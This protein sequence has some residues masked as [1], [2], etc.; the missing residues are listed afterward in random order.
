MKE[1]LENAFL[2]LEKKYGKGT[3]LTLNNFKLEADVISSGSLNLNEA[4]GIGGFPRGRIVEVYGRESSGKTLLV[5][6]TIVNAQK[7]GGRC[8][9]I[10][11][12]H[13]LDRK[14]CEIQGVNPDLFD[15]AQP[16]S[17]EE[18]LDIAEL[19]VRTG[20]YAVIACD[21]VAA[22]VPQ[23]EEESQMEDQ[24]MGLQARL[25]GKAMRKLNAP[26]SESNT[27]MMFI[28]Q[29]RDSIG[30]YGGQV[31]PGGKA[32]KFYSSI[33]VEMAKGDPMKDGANVVGF[34]IKAKVVKNKLASPFAVCE[35]PF[36]LGKGFSE[37]DELIEKAID[38]DLITASGAWYTYGENRVQGKSSLRELISTEVIKNELKD[39][40]GIK[41]DVQTLNKEGTEGT[42]A[43]GRGKKK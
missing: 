4:L 42:S 27:L 21:S 22:L 37:E 16:S 5:L 12:E 36:L 13:A 24:H 39:K 38:L 7:R 19:M 29:V 9:F 35:I 26:V 15:I 11:V 2:V 43:T 10:D 1:S 32:L 3:I 23:A 33:R 40:L 30:G 14:W 18:A 28:N 17:G 6:N 41:E 25:M 34:Y 20:L 31:T 8:L